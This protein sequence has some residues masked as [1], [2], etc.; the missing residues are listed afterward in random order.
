M[1]LLR[2]R[3]ENDAG[4]DV[5]AI[6][7]SG[8]PLARDD[9]PAI[10][11]RDLVRRFGDFVAVDHTTFDVAHGEIFGL[12]GPNGA[13]KTTTFRM[14]CGLL[15]ASSGEARVAGLDMRTAAADAR[16]RI[17]YVSQKFALYG[18][19]SVLENLHFFGQAYGLRGKRLRERSE[20][21]LRQ[22]DLRG[23]E[24]K[25]AG[26]LAGGLKQRLAMAVG[27]L[28]EPEILFLDEPT[29]GADPLARRAFWRR[30]TALAQSGTTIV[31]TTHFMEEAEYCD[32]M[33]I[34]DA[35]KILALGTPAEVRR[36]AG[37]TDTQR[38]DMEQAFIGIVEKARAERK[39]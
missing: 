18:N 37:E 36:Q 35:G 11:I 32:R 26:E 29:S 30:I 33:V 15:P 14:L 4:A 13:G 34:Q 7:S 28:H 8:A 25:R 3:Q 27:L 20:T 31:I 1:M 39:Q 6:E 22:L 2:A 23:W 24:Q 38:L 17:G 19:L 16:R 12:L 21:V 9:A 5:S 10:A